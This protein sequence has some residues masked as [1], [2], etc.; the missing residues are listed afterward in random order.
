M[1]TNLTKAL[2]VVG[3]LA[4]ILGAIVVV[5]DLAKGKG[6]IGPGWVAILVGVFVIFFSYAL[7]RSNE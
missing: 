4:V 3:G 2:P 7:Q 6:I 1:K 5:M